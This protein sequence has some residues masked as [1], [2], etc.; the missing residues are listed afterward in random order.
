MSSEAEA[1]RVDFV[2][3]VEE[4]EGGEEGDG[5]PI[6]ATASKPKKPRAVG[7]SL[8]E[9]LLVCCGPE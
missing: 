3:A 1:G 4:D 6:N 8:L 9:D 2:E 7:F 5:G